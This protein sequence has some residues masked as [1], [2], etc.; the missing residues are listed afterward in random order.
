MLLGVRL[1]EE[2]DRL[3]TEVARQQGRTR[4]EIVREALRRYL[5]EDR[6]LAEARRQSRLVADEA[7]EEAAEFTWSAADLGSE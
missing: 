7:D 4:S 6:F 5:D 3:L 2:L 1:D